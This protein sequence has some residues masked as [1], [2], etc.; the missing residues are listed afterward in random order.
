MKFHFT[1]NGLQQRAEFYK[2]QLSLI[3]RAMAALESGGAMVCEVHRQQNAPEQ[4]PIMVEDFDPGMAQDASRRLWDIHNAGKGGC[5]R[6][7]LFIRIGDIRIAVDPIDAGKAFTLDSRIAEFPKQMVFEKGEKL[8]SSWYAD[9]PTT[10][11]R[12]ADALI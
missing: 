6:A 7:E 11:P 8:P 10:K 9:S 2:R 1:H 4:I 12:L 3:E 5:P